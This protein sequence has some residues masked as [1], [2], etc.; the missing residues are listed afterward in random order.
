MKSKLS[1]IEIIQ[2]FGS[3]EAYKEQLRKERKEKHREYMR[4]YMQVHFNTPEYK[5]YAKQYARNYTRDPEHKRLYNC[6]AASNRILRKLGIRVDGYEIHHCWG[7][8]DPSK[9]VY[10]PRRL[11]RDI[12][13]ALNEAGID[14]KNNHWDH[15][16]DIIMNYKG[17][18]LI[19]Q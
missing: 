5:E 6:R 12:H 3:H 4:E 1:D 17:F 2:Q 8:D 10:I 14:A 13:I 18:T 16:K 15:I 9:F 19:K 11:H 7:Y